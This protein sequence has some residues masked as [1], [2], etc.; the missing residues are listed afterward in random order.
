[1]LSTGLAAACSAE[2]HKPPR[3]STPA[4]V[5]SSNILDFKHRS[6]KRATSLGFSL[7]DGD[8]GPERDAA[9]WSLPHRVPEPP[10]QARGRPVTHGDSGPPGLSLRE[11]SVYPEG[12]WAWSR[13]CPVTGVQEPLLTC[14]G[15]VLLPC[16]PLWKCAQQTRGSP[17]G[18]TF[19]PHPFSLSLSPGAEV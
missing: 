8:S 7:P 19:A 13:G 10:P 1:M 17:G 9:C 3:P 18:G 11:S 5:L 12:P 16:L 4:T 14:L 6:D 2:T 15:S